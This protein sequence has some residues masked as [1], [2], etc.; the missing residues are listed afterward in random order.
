M[1]KPGVRG[2]LIVV[3]WLLVA[4]VLAEAVLLS[5]VVVHYAAAGLFCPHTS[6]PASSA[7]SHQQ[8][9]MAPSNRDKVYRGEV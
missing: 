4:A 9:C 7:F 6:K 1:C 8:C 2:V 3:L 5:L